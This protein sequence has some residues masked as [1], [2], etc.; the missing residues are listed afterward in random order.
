MEIWLPVLLNIEAGKE[1]WHSQIKGTLQ[2]RAVLTDIS[3]ICKCDYLFF[4][5]YGFAFYC[6]NEFFLNILWFEYWHF[7][8]L[9]TSFY[10][11]LLLI[12]FLHDIYIRGEYVKKIVY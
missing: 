5:Y 4:N 8:K 3:Q 10:I 11:T 6:I 12:L 1:Q 2:S 9:Y 7:G